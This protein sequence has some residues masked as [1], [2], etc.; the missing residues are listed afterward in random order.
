DFCQYFCM[1]ETTG[2]MLFICDHKADVWPI[3]E[4]SPLYRCN[5]LL[6]LA[7]FLHCFG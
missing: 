6:T 5:F 1:P 3:T 7:H 4:F 2:C